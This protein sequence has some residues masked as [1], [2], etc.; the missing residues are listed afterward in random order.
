MENA[1]DHPPSRG[2][3]KRARTRAALL[4]A[5][6]RVVARKGEAASVVDVI[7]EAGVSNGTFYNYFNDRDAFIDALLLHVAGDLPGPAI[8]RNKGEDTAFRFARVAAATIA[9]AAA[10]PDW[11][12]TMLRFETL[13]PEQQSYALAG[14]RAGLARGHAAQRFTA[15]EEEIVPDLVL[16][17]ILKTIQ[18]ALT[19][20]A[21]RRDVVEAIAFMLTALGLPRSE[22]LEVAEAGVSQSGLDLP[23]AAP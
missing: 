13:R 18:R 1:T 4:E 3:K 7:T 12:W 8:P 16:A 14:L 9:Q 10:R 6:M 17:M 5:G 15:G 2:H 19:G 22:A 23:G 20:R 21:G 11:G